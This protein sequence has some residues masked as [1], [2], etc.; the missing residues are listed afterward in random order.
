MNKKV[1]DVFG[2]V[3]NTEIKENISDMTLSY[4]GINRENRFL[5]CEAVSN[6]YIFSNVAE[7]IKAQIKEGMG[8]NT[9]VFDIVYEGVELKSEFFDDIFVEIKKKYSGLNGFFNDAE[10]EFQSNV[11][12]INLRKENAL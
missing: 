6:K 5:K 11:L 10:F 9:I 3:L 4:C 8:L 2:G 12:K 7:S 1:I